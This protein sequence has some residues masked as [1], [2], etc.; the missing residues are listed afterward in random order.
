MFLDENVVWAAGDNQL[1]LKTTNGGAML[2][3]IN[4]GSK[5]KIPREI[6]LEQNYPNPFNPHTKI[7]FSLE[8]A[9][10]VNISIYNVMGQ[11]V[12]KVLNNRRLN[13]GFHT[14]VWDGRDNQGRELPT[15]ITFTVLKQEILGKL[16]R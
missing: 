11:E 1:I 3:N 9:G 5:A 2:S 15:G 14:K 6:N 13:A 7:K 8:K 10:L 4:E 16:K 12:K